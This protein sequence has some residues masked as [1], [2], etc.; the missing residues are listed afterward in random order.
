MGYAFWL[1][2]SFAGG[3]TFGYFWMWPENSIHAVLG[4]HREEGEM[5]SRTI[6]PNHEW[7]EPGPAPT[8]RKRPNLSPASLCCDGL[9]G[10]CRR[11]E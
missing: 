4:A 5:M 9:R 1:F 11:R 7:V 2:V 6:D 10:V 8:N 3:G